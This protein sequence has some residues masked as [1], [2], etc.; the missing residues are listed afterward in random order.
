MIKY[1][2]ITDLNKDQASVIKENGW[3]VFT[4]C[5]EGSSYFNKGFTWANRIGYII[6]SED[7]GVD[8]IDSWNE[9]HKIA[10]SDDEFAKEVNALLKPIEDKCYVFLRKDPA[11][12]QSKQVWT[13]EGL[14]DA[15]KQANFWDKFKCEYYAKEDFDKMHKKI[16]R[17]N[18]KVKRDTEKALEILRANGFEV[19]SENFAALKKRG[20]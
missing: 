13:N 16:D 3:C 8:Y 14:E 5:A 11:R 2:E 9:L 4:E 1:M 20:K 7:P 6:F 19:V 18:N 15:K 17:H 10:E 12:Y